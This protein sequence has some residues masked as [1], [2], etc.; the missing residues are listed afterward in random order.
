MPTIEVPNAIRIGQALTLTLRD[1]AATKDCHIIQNSI[2]LPDPVTL[3]P[4]EPF[5]YFPEA[6]GHYIIRGTDCAASFDVLVDIDVHPGPVLAG[7]LWF[8]SAWTAAVGNGHESA[9]M[10]M[11]PRLIRAGSVVYDI[12]AN[13]GLYA[14]RFLSLVNNSGYVYCFEPNPV[15]THYLSH[16]LA[17]TGA[18]N[19]LILPFAIADRRGAIDLILNPDNHGLGSVALAK[20]GVKI[21]VD[22]MTLDEGVARFGF[23][24]PDVIK[25]DIEGGETLAINGMRETIERHRPALIFELHGRQAARETLKGLGAYLWQIPGE[26]EQ[27]S[28]RQL[29]DIFPEACLQV[30]GA[31][32]D[33]G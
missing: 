1:C 14:T 6:P 10:T 11:L 32:T 29:A 20:Q 18:K 28:A 17:A 9:V 2:L 8:P 16:N 24:P 31:A 21:K 27:Y 13:I 3:Q 26:N 22:T 4:D 23:R 30:I 25:M 12:G 19:Y 5:H 7:R 33:D 15:A